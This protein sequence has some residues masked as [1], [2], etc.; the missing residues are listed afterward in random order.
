MSGVYDQLVE[1]FE[2]EG[3]PRVMA[4]LVLQVLREPRPEVISAG[5]QPDHWGAAFDAM[6]ISVN[7]ADAAEIADRQ[8]RW[9]RMRGEIEEL[10]CRVW[11]LA[12]DENRW[13]I[14][15]PSIDVEVD[16]HSGEIEGLDYGPNVNFDDLVRDIRRMI[17]SKERDLA[18]KT[19]RRELRKTHDWDNKLK[20]WVPKSGDGPLIASRTRR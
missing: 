8:Q 19:R 1:I 11:Q 5:I 3:E 17:Q 13:K 12:N 16:L 2:T 15:G 9:P 4:R 7:A 18:E 6:L 14:E 20:G 10:G